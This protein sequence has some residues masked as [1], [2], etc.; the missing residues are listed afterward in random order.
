[1]GGINPSD[2]FAEAL[3]NY[4]S[5]ISFLKTYGGTRYHADGGQKDVAKA[6]GIAKSAFCE[7][8]NRVVGSLDPGQGQTLKGEI[9]KGWQNSGFILVYFW[10]Y[11]RFMS[12]PDEPIGLSITA[13]SAGESYSCEIQTLDKV[14]PDQPKRTKELIAKLLSFPI[15]DGFRYFG[16][17][18]VSQDPKE[19]LKVVQDIPDSQLSNF[20]LRISAKITDILGPI[21]STDIASANEGIY[22]RLLSWT[23]QL[24]PLYRHLFFEDESVIETHSKAA[25]D[26]LYNKKDFLDEVFVDESFYD[27]AIT[28][29]HE[30]KNILLYGAPGVGKTFL[31]KRL[32]YADMGSKKASHVAC[33]QF[34]QSYSYE[35]FVEGFRPNSTEGFHLVHGLFWEFAEK[36]RH[37]PT[38]SYYLIID[39]I[40]R[41][42]V[43]KIFGE[44][45]LLIEG[46]KRS[47]EYGVD[48]AYGNYD[49][50][51]HPTEEKFYVPANLYLIGMMN[52]ADRSLT[53]MDYALRRRFSFIDVHPAFSNDHFN[54]KVHGYARGNPE[55]IAEIDD[56]IG[57]MRTLNAE[58]SKDTTLGED[59]QI[60]HSYFLPQEGVD[61]STPESAKT[62]L[63]RVIKYDILP[64]LREYMI[65]GDLEE[66][67]KAAKEKLESYLSK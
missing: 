23:Q 64:L 33:L 8:A 15:P 29:L 52:S 19:I 57:D 66:G 7:L 28:L 55:A 42:N 17:F 3:L 13:N 46:D 4:Q 62:W 47:Q 44:L 16:K 25:V 43:S 45:L 30:K 32:A 6:G 40:N 12:F 58:I 67:V 56:V 41:G 54:E 22:R 31:A 53:R 60:G 24:L 27:D 18:V 2:Y 63:K 39:E 35:D 34:H 50:G 37:N 20:G 10:D 36:A 14:V 38:E 26:P 51:M 5:P 49:A 48:L 61:A 65:A 21:D 59:F 1:M 9:T 11:M